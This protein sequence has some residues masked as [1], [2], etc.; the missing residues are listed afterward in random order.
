[1]RTP[2]DINL[3]RAAAP[4]WRVDVVEETGSTNADLL[5]RPDIAGSVLLAEYQTAGRGRHGR[6]WSAPARSQVAMSV[7]VD[8]TAPYSV[9]WNTGLFGSGPHTLTAVAK[10]TANKTTTSA[11]RTVTI[12]APDIVDPVVHITSP[13]AGPVAWGTTAITATATDNVQVSKVDFYVDGTLVGSDSSAPYS[14]N[15]ASTVVGNH[16]ITA[17]AT[18]TSNNTGTDGPV[19]VSVPA[20]STPPTAPGT[21]SGS[22]GGQTSVNLSWGAATDDR[23]VVAGYVVTRDGVDLPGLVTGTSFTDTGLTAGTLYTYTVKA[24]DPTGN[25]GPASNAVPVTT[26][27]AGPTS[28]FSYDWT[29]PDG[30]G[31]PSTF[32]TTSANGSLATS[33]NAGVLTVNDVA[34]ANARAI[35]NAVAPRA[36]TDVTLSYAWSSTAA[37]AYLDVWLRGSGGWANSYRPANGY[38]VEMSSSSGTLSILKAMTEAGVKNLI[39]SSTCA[40]YGQPARMPITEDLPYSWYA[41]PNL[42]HAT[43]VDLEPLFQEVDLKL[44]RRITLSPHG[45]PRALGQLGA[46]L[47]AGSAIYVLVRADQ[48]PAEL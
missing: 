9:N 23:G 44:E 18:D 12:P 32:T 22:A 5:A 38:G 24:K 3:I 45:R 33:G 8:T 28:L 25:V 35:I 46:N 43:L 30:I 20:D 47:M 42:H 1:M 15:W 26:S 48:D 7:G 31:W 17:I 27:P 11:P 39:V 36:D 19:T 10:D 13:A 6:Q 16:D 4:Q 40:T 29:A 21:L 2:L 34:G 41:T 37:R 14:V